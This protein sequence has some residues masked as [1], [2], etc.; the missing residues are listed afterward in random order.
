MKA[1][2]V[3]DSIININVAKRMLEKLNIEVEFVLNG[4]DCI[5]KVKTENYNVIFMDI[6][7]PEMDGVETLHNLQQIEGFNTKVIALTADVDI[8]AETRYLKEGFNSYIPKP[9][10]FEKLTSVVNS[11]NK[12]I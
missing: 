4:K 12:N 3:D 6:M 1:L 7:M 10:N 8:D 11:I 9:I 2:I 5:E